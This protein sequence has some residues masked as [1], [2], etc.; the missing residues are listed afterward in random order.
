MAATTAARGLPILRSYFSRIDTKS[1]YAP[2]D[3]VFTNTVPFTS[4]RST[5]ATVPPRMASIAVRSGNMPRSLAKW[6]N[7]PAGRTARGMPECI[8]ADA[9]RCTVPSPPATA[10]TRV[11]AAASSMVAP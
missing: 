1:V 8:A 7:V 6:L 9:A 5:F 4:P 10:R 3:A 11:E 2:I